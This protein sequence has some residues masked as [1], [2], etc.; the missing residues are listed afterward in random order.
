MP[1]VAHTPLNYV[2][3]FGLTSRYLSLEM[4]AS[5]RKIAIS[6]SL[7]PRI[8]DARRKPLVRRKVIERRYEISPRT[9]DVWMK[10]RRIPF[11]KIGGT[12][13]FSIAKCDEAL[14]RFEIK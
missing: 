3:A 2:V 10:A 9:L 14:E 12:L 4:A 5:S 8:Y 7:D 11:Y 6:R 13:F 1:N